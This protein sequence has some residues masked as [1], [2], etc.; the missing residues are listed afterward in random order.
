MEATKLMVSPVGNS[1]N[2][3]SFEVML[4]SACSFIVDVSLSYVYLSLFY[5]TCFGL[6]GHLQVCMM[7]YFYTPEGICFAAFLALSCTWLHY[8]H[9]HTIYIYIYISIYI[10][11]I[12]LVSSIFNLHGH[13]MGFTGYVSACVQL[14]YVGFHCLSLHVS[15]YM[16][17][18]RC[19]IWK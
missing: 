18:S 5:S 2:L 10:Y 14:Y 9:T 17:I 8:I 11:T 7:F 19:E 15:A 3:I 4:P 16:A 12:V 13:W 1:S 6:H